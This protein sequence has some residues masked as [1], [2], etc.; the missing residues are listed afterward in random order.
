MVTVV[1]WPG[2]LAIANSSISRRTPGQAQAE[3]A[4]RAEAV[5]ERA[6]DVG[7]ARSAVAGDDLDA[8]ARDLEQVDHD[9]ARAGE[10]DDVA[11]H[12]GHGRGDDREV[13]GPEGQAR[14]ELACGPT[15]RDDVG[16]GGDGMRQTVVALLPALEQR[17][18][19]P[20]AGLALE[21]VLGR[22]HLP[23]ASLVAA[24]EGDEH[25]PA[26]LGRQAPTCAAAEQVLDTQS[27]TRAVQLGCHGPG[28]AA[29]AR[30]EGARVGAA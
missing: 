17:L 23:L 21:Q 9:L 30:S 24:A 5:V 10:T 2:S 25:R 26:L 20:R 12:L 15:G 11:A 6:V 22:A 4:V 1:P 29:L 7:D 18:A 14:R 16:I 27:G 3:S 13:G 8:T 28:R 19:Q